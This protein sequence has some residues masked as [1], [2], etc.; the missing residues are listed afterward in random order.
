[1]KRAWLVVMIAVGMSSCMGQMAPPFSGQGPDPDEQVDVYV[2]AMMERLLDVDDVNYRFENKVFVYL[3]WKDPRAYNSMVD[4]T[5]R[6]RNGSKE[7]CDRPCSSTSIS[8]L[9]RL[10]LSYHFSD[11]CC[12]DVWLPTLR[13]LNVYELPEGRLQ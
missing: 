6:F 1:M 13:M 9:S 7:V 10:S 4:S 8:S 5:K 12:D 11:T 2:S 3:S